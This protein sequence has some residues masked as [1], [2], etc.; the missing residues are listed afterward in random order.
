[1]KRLFILSLI[2]FYGISGYSQDLIKNKE[3][4]HA[5]PITSVAVNSDGTVILTVS[6]DKRA[7][8]WEAKTAK[9][10]KA[11]AF[12]DVTNSVA[13]N[14]SNKY[15]VCGGD[16]K[17]VVVFDSKSY[18]PIRILRE[19]TSAVTS[20]A[21]NPINDNVASGAKNNDIKLFD[22]ISGSFMTSMIGHT[23]AVT[24]LAFSPDG[25]YLASGSMDKTVR[26]WDAG[27]GMLKN[28]IDADPKG[29]LSVCYSADGNFIA[30]GGASGNISLWDARSGSKIA[31][32][33]DLS[34]A[35]NT[36][37]FSPDVQYLAAAGDDN[38]IVVYSLESRQ[39]A[40]QVNAHSDG[41]TCIAFSDK[42]N[43]FVS[44][45]NDGGLRIWDVK[46]LKIGKKKFVAAGPDK[47]KVLC[48]PLVLREDNNNG[49]IELNE[50][51]TI[52]FSVENKGQGQAYNL[53]AKVALE[54]RIKGLSFE[55]EILIGN[56]DVEKE[57]NV[58]ISL[59]TEQDLETTSG[60]FIVSVV[61]GNG[62]DPTP[63]RVNFQTRG[64]QQYSYIMVLGHA[65]SSATGKA[66]IGAPI[67]LKLKLKNTS[68]G[69]A[70]DIKVNYLFPDKVLAVDKVS[71]LIPSFPAGEE[72]EVTV[73]F[74]ASKEFMGKAIKM[75]LTIDGAAFT[76]ANDLI[77]K[78]TMNESL[79]GQEVYANVDVQPEKPL[80]RGGGDPLKGLNVS[81][82]K[83]MVIGNYYALIIGIDKYSGAWSP[84]Q[85]AV[86]DAKA[87]EA[88]LKSRYKIDYFRKLYNEQAT[89]ENIIKELE[90]LIENA[91]E[92]DN[93]FIYYSG[94]GEFK[95]ALNKGYWVPV[96]AKSQSTSN[97]ISNSDLQTYLNG[98]KS[99]H[100]LLVSDACFSGDI[101]RGNT[102]SV[103]FE[104]SEKYFK[105][106][107]NLASRQAITSGGIEPVMDGGRDGHSVF[108]YYFLKT[109]TNN[110]SRYFDAG[111]LYTKIKIPIIN[112]SEQT[113]KISPIKNTGDEGGQFI[114]IK[115]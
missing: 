104:E 17:M 36:V 70:T 68:K 54:N 3:N 102:I 25:L 90:W 27:S 57:Q 92:K 24:C 40:N 89:R 1:M 9:K 39:I 75:G 38:K 19:N 49:I 105:E 18:K 84:L 11:M 5:G 66:E 52:T 63:L 21:F 107:H 112:N 31:D 15:F 28:T 85:N 46:R 109:L 65:Y 43:V 42:G 58:T 95:Q 4:A 73:Q 59:K 97:Y 64:V 50:N 29:I 103:P 53:V 94:H 67:T 114:F 101:F 88:M 2:L 106:V 113:P 37:A 34:G 55:K 22:G 14:S 96:D 10:I 48:S 13:Y 69:D 80:Y 91:K 35:V 108:A 81:R 74:Y 71:E 20:V 110:S 62:N 115:K 77:L 93:V 30:S 86:N 76:N 45:G 60:T 83:E 23:K 7:S 32:F 41:I 111:Q 26:I 72:K 47:P 33:T 79:P 16:D 82:A 100:T 61:E 6:A 51:P 44:V 78:I 56:L 99:K 12:K 87:V 8:I 98:I